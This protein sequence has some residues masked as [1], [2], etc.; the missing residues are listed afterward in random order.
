MKKTGKIV[1]AS[2]LVVG[3][4]LVAPAA[5]A[6][7]NTVT[8]AV[9]G[10]TL[11]A[12]A[13]DVT[14]TPVTTAHTDQDSAGSLTVT[15]DDSSG[16]GAGWNVT[17]QV[18]ALAYSGTN[19]GTDIPAA[20]VSV[21]SVGAATLTAG[22]A[23]D[24]TGTDAA[25]TGPQSANVTSGVSGTLDTPVKVLVAGANF[26]QGTYS[27]PVNLNLTVPANSRAGSYTGTLTTTITSA[28]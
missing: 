19:G 20:N 2:T 17:Q 9:T 21:T 13:S 11:T 28:P 14:L 10:G 26:G 22:Q 5:F 24:S 4:L 12:S 25:P 23:I 27:L 16:T 3:S 8:Q 7:D 6:A 15:A 18:S 1:V